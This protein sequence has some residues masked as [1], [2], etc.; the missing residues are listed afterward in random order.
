MAG[1]DDGRDE[2]LILEDIEQVA[3]H[4]GK[5]PRTVYRWVARGMPVEDDGRFDLRKI[6]VWVR[7]R[8]GMGAAASGGVRQGAPEE[9]PMDLGEP[10]ADSSLSEQNG[11]PDE[12]NGVTN[13][14]SA[15]TRGPKGQISR[16]TT[17]PFSNDGSETVRDDR[18]YWDKENKRLQ[19]QQRK[20]DIQ[21]K[22]KE[23]I[24]R[25]TVEDM[26]VARVSAVKQGLLSL[27]RALPPQLIVCRSEVEM[28]VVISKAVHDLLETYSR[29]LPSHLTAGAENP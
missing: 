23:L 16:E 21:K 5:S 29:P 25:K 24:E 2:N 13:E 14:Q 15:V 9:S 4:F 10:M 12:Q 6:S 28:S 11:G 18:D 1:I 19:V 27:S 20:I 26:F 8:K 7:K 22:K 3:R 17:L